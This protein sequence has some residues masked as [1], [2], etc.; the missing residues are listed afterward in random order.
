M[1]TRH[2]ACQWG[3]PTS[4][5]LL[6][7][8]SPAGSKKLG[9]AGP[10]SAGQAQP[11]SSQACLGE[12]GQ[13]RQQGLRVLEQSLGCPG[14]AKSGWSRRGWRELAP[15]HQL[16]AKLKQYWESQPAEMSGPGS[17]GGGDRVKACLHPKGAGWRHW[18]CPLVSNE[19]P[20]PW[21]LPGVTNG[22][23]Q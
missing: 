11:T 22:C 15:S 4:P 13:A 7:S 19:L 23:Q 20:P 18:A 6:L 1:R 5:D 21:Y 9:L 10:G 12:V 2:S 16:P 3:P 8:L 17:C 14:K